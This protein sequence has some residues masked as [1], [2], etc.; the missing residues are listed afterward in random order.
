MFEGKFMPT[1]C[2]LAMMFPMLEMAS[3]GHIYYNKE[4]FYIYNIDNPL[5]DCVVHRPLQAKIEHHIRSQKRYEPLSTSSFR[6]IL[7]DSSRKTKHQQYSGSVAKSISPLN[8]QEA[9]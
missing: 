7:E 3:K 6:K 4:I 2:D 1:T 5:M 9:A 8:T